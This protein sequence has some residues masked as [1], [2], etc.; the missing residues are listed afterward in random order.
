MGREEVPAEAAFLAEAE[1]RLA[2]S[3][4]R[5]RDLL[6]TIALSDAFRTASGTREA[7]AVETPATSAASASSR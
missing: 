3:G 6:R 5:W 2:E 1:A 4:Y 7:E